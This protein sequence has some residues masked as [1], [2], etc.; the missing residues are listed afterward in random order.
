M[1]EKGL[2]SED[3]FFTDLNKRIFRYLKNAYECGDIY[4]SGINGEFTE[5]EVGRISHIKVQRMR[6]TVN[7]DNELEESIA[8]LKKSIDK[9]NSEKTNTID[10]L[11]ERLAKLRSGG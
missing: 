2:L 1:F 7:G 4:L 11:N 10:S 6:F 3:D 5:D 8:S 9:K